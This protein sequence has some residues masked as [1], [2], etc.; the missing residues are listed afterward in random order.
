L[1]FHLATDIQWPP[2]TSVFDNR[3]LGVVSNTFSNTFSGRRRLPTLAVTA[4][5]SLSAARVL[6]GQD[7]DLAWRD[8]APAQH[9]THGLRHHIRIGKS[10]GSR[11]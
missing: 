2:T 3:R 7:A 9:H 5:V 10:G 1:G 4:Y 8:T 6:R 11:P